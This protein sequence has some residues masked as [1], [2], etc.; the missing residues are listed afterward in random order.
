MF[1]WRSTVQSFNF[2]LLFQSL[3]NKLTSKINYILIIFETILFY[4]EFIVHK[5]KL[6]TVF[7]KKRENIA[8]CTHFL[9]Q[10]L[11]YLYYRTI[12]YGCCV[13]LKFLEMLH[14]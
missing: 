7:I 5:L 6:L 13:Y 1:C 11:I 14:K 3:R 8:V 9:F 12:P 10:L 2:F 4:T